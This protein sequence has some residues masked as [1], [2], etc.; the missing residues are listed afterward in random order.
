MEGERCP[1]RDD[2]S[3]LGPEPGCDKLLLFAR[4]EVHEPVDP[5]TNANGAPALDVVHEELGRIAS[6][7]RLLGRE[8]A[9][10]TRRRLEESVPVRAVWRCLGHAQNVSQ[11][12]VLCKYHLASIPIVSA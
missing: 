6:L 3:S 10:L 11:I 8:Q 1:V 7:S 5:A 9:L 4:G 12:L 2:A